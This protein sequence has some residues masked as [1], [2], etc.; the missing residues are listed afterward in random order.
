MSWV[1]QSISLATLAFIAVVLFIA[2]A[3]PFELLMDSIDD[4]VPKHIDDPGYNES[5]T[6]TTT[7]LRT[8]FGLFFAL[9]LI[10]YIIGAILLSHKDEGEEYIDQ[11]WGGGYK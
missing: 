2:L 10:S 6:T 11:R 8:I 1:K 4:E 9:A 5:I 3:Q 7:N